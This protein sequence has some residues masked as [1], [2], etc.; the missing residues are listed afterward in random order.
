M[1]KAWANMTGTGANGL[2]TINANLNISSINKTASSTFSVTFI[3][4]MPDANYV[5]VANHVSGTGTAMAN[6]L[7]TT[8]FTLITYN[9]SN[10]AVANPVGIQFA[11]FGN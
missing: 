3:S 11:V 5:V 8:G 6:N 10:S 2:Q 4:A 7:S 9:N 1:A